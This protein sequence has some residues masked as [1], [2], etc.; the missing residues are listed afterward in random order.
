MWPRIALLE[1]WCG[2]I[3]ARMNRATEKEMPQRVN[4]EKSDLS[5]SM[6]RALR[7]RLVKACEEDERSVS[8]AVRDAV[9]KWLEARDRQKRR[10]GK[11]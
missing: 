3:A 2:N 4:P 5:V 6:G 8:D 7:G 9:R 11:T 10:I 1:D